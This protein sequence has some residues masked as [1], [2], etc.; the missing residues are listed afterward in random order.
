MTRTRG[1]ATLVDMDPRG[2]LRGAKDVDEAYWAHKY[3]G[4][5]RQDRGGCTRP[6]G[7]HKVINRFP[8]VQAIISVYF[9]HVGLCF[10]MCACD[11]ATCGALD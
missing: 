9:F 4:P 10:C 6:N 7:R 2:R 1:G 3:S 8:L 5:M 11:V